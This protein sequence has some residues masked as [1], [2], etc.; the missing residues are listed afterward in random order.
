MVVG[1]WNLEFEI[2]NLGFGTWD[3]ERGTCCYVVPPRNDLE[4]VASSYLLAM[5]WNLDMERKAWTG[6]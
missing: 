3:L 6:I 1:N 4:P 2:W 5:T